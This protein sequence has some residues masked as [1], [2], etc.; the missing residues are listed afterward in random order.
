[1]LFHAKK[2]PPPRGA[3]SAA[4]NV[5]VRPVQKSLLVNSWHLAFEATRALLSYTTFSLQSLNNKQR[6][7]FAMI[8]LFL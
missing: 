3:K 8:S 1:L 5:F 2:I 4:P 7:I 6:K